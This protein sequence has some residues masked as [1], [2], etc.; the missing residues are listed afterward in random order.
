LIRQ[1]Y[2]CDVCGTEKKQTNHWFVVREVSEELRVSGWN[3]RNRERPGVKHM[4]GQACVHKLVDDFMARSI[5]ARMQPAAGD[6]AEATASTTDASLTSNAAYAESEAPARVPA[7]A[8]P[9][10]RRAPAAAPI[11]LPT[12]LS[13]EAPVIP[14]ADEAELYASRTWRADAWERERARELR[15]AERR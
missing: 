3:S 7:L 1:A 15:S 11:A 4:C 12:P 13:A 6:T 5:S 14:F 9:P 8:M 2:S 10:P